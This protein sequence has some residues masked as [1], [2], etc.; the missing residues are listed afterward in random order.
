MNIDR[1]AKTKRFPVFVNCVCHNMREFL[2]VDKIAAGCGGV[3][4]G[5][6]GLQ[7]GGVCIDSRQV[8]AGDCFFAIKGE[9]FD[10]H[11]FV[12]K[13]FESGATCAVV[14]KSFDVSSIKGLLNG[15]KRDLTPLIV[16]EDTTLALGNLAAYYRS[17]LTAKVVAITGSVGKTTARDMISGVLSS[18]YKCHSAKKSFN[19]HIGLPLTILEADINSEVLVVE[20]GTNHPG[21][22]EYLTKIANPDIAVIT[23]VA[24]AHIEYFGTLR[25][26]AKEKASI[27]LGLKKDGSLIVNGDSDELV[28]Y[29]ESEN[30]PYSSYSIEDKFELAGSLGKIFIDGMWVEVPLAGRG[31]LENA[32]AAW[33]VCREFGFTPEDFAAAIGTAIAPDMRLNVIEHEGVRIINDCYNANP[34]SMANALEV[35]AGFRGESKR[36]VAVCG[37]MLELG[38]SSRRYHAELGEAIAEKGINV[39]VAVGKFAPDVAKAAEKCGN[40][41]THCFENTD[42]LCQK[43]KAIIKP[44]DTVL[45]KASRSIAL[46]KALNVLIGN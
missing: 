30:I 22:I 11:E 15:E 17:L 38:D 45:L 20:L 9:R 40:T 6:G 29:L 5:D 34:Q 36:L 12:Q 23:K 26:I 41:E 8:K 10:G 43:I 13:A 3:L 35:L 46:E 44:G 4:N 39:L 18:R 31:N 28:N 2:D 7:C 27:A 37:D 19:N 24:A 32:L 1:E 33:N 21:E 25:E 42:A 16:V 14:D